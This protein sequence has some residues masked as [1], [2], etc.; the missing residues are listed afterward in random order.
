MQHSVCTH[1]KSCVHKVCCLFTCVWPCDI[2]V[3]TALLFYLFVV[4]TAEYTQ[5]FFVALVL[6]ESQTLRN[7]THL[8]LICS[9]VLK[10]R[11]IRRGT[12]CQIIYQADTQTVHNTKVHFDKI[13]P[14]DQLQPFISFSLNT[15]NMAYKKS[16]NAIYCQNLKFEMRYRL[17]SVKSTYL[18]TN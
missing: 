12:Q 7:F 9:T 10:D 11:L 15:Q 2:T 3:R 4:L 6:F 5:T 1:S 18:F 16:M 14:I 17:F 13:L 8:S